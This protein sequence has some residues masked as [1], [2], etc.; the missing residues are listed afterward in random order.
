[1]SA[2][3]TALGLALTGLLG[4]LLGAQTFSP[5]AAGPAPAAGP[6]LALPPPPDPAPAQAAL[7]S[8]KQRWASAPTDNPRETAPD[9]AATPWR[10]L[11]I[12]SDGPARFAL[13]EQAEKILR[14]QPGDPLTA[15]TRI[16]TIAPNGIHTTAD[17]E[18]QFHPLY[19]EKH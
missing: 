14:L 19:A 1:M 15:D 16:T 17:G 3:K 10:L 2:P 12:I 11:G 4:A 7:A 6:E 8:L 13:I 5:P 18:P 9:A